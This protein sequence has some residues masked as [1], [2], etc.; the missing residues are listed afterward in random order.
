MINRLALTGA[1]RLRSRLQ[2]DEAPTGPEFFFAQTFAGYQLEGRV[3]AGS[4]A[5][6]ST[7]KV[8]AIHGARSDYSRLNAILYP[9]Q[10]LGIASL[11]FNLS[12]HGP[13]ADVALKET[14]LRHNLQEAL[15]FA[16]HL[17][18]ELSTVIGHSLGGALA[19]KVAQ[20]HRASVRRIVLFCP[21]LY[22]EAAWQQPFGPT[23]KS[24]ISVPYGF[25]DSP[26]LEFL[27]TFD[28][29]VLLVIGEYDGLQATTFGGIAGTSVGTQQMS[30]RVINSAIPYE[31]IEA[32]EKNLAPHQLRK[33]VL[34]GCD[35]AVSTWLRENPPRAVELASEI[36]R[37][38]NPGNRSQVS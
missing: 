25:L 4:A 17:G 30:E 15:Q 23:F 26:S 28:G 5:E 2:F 7:P 19:L 37:F 11:S 1:S 9:L 35:H 32:I 22:A 8:L 20:A 13:S 33:I 29:E 3:L 16:G 14:S 34:P 24:A 27:R 10:A 18:G 21:A 6:T 36:A 12:G 38:I 31:V